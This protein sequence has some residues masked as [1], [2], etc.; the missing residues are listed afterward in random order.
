MIA[1]EKEAAEKK[2]NGSIEAGDKQEPL[3]T[4]ATSVEES[5]STSLL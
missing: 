3:I 2:K 4:N 5:E 1:K